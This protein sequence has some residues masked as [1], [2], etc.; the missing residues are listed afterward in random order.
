MM[1]QAC[2]RPGSQPS[3]H[4]RMLMMESAEQMPHLTQTAM[5]GKRMAMRPRKMSDVH[6]FGI[7]MIFSVA[8]EFEMFD[9]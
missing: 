4:R 7:W 5:G 2:R 9:E 8:L 1:Y 3:M 6:I